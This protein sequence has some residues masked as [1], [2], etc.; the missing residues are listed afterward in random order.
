MSANSEGAGGHVLGKRISVSSAQKPLFLS[1]QNAVC[2][3][4]HQYLRC[5]ERQRYRGEAGRRRDGQTEVPA[6]E[7]RAGSKDQESSWV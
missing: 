7:R 2:R 3:E 6:E 5:G 1:T 4:A